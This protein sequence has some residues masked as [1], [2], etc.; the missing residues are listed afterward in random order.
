[1]VEIRVKPVESERGQEKDDDFIDAILTTG[2]SLTGGLSS[3]HIYCSVAIFGPDGSEC[4][5]YN[6]H[7]F[8]SVLD[9]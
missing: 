5:L 6:K 2:S 4:H 9:K 3:K 1:M 8:P 7:S